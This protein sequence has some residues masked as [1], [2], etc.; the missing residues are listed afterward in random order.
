MVHVKRF[1]LAIIIICAAFPQFTSAQGR[2]AEVGGTDAASAREIFQAALSAFGAQHYRVALHQFERVQ[3]LAPSAALWFNMARCHEELGHPGR[4]A[5]YLE[6]Y[7]RDR[8]DAPDADA[9]RARIAH[10][11]A[12]A[13]AA[14][15]APDRA[16]RGSLIVHV[17]P[18]DARVSLDG[19]EI[20]VERRRGML[21]LPVGKHALRVAAPG[22]AQRPAS[23]D[24]YPG[25]LT[26]AYVEL[27]D[28]TL[29]AP[30]A[31]RSPGPWTWALA[32]ATVLS[33]AAAVT[34]H[35]AGDRAR[36][37]GDDARGLREARDLAYGTLAATAL[38]TLVA[39]FVEP[40]ATNREGLDRAPR[41][42]LVW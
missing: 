30:L 14:E 25:S 42:A 26:R 1:S 18:A 3:A 29:R 8:V 13:R 32:A 20:P 2:P 21:S 5:A 22:G 37:A 19:E 28:T 17:Q 15:G 38:S 16:T 40:I 34:L 24:I 4:A 23:V 33:G 35:L 7:L 31:S 11:R 41:G 6:R 39:Y 9:V 12:G 10:L 36:A 27:P